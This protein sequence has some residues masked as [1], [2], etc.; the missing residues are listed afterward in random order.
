MAGFLIGWAVGTGVCISLL[1]LLNARRLQY[2]K[3]D[4]GYSGGRTAV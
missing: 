2:W 4:I 3:I 1:A